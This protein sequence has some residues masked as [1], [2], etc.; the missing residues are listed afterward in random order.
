MNRLVMLPDSH[1]LLNDRTGHGCGLPAVAAPWGGGCGLQAQPLL[2]FVSQKYIQDG[3]LIYAVFPSG[4]GGCFVLYML[5]AYTERLTG[6][7]AA[8]G[9]Q[10]AL[11]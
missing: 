8:T 1:S 3:R 7:R 4:T 6:T 10:E 2:L 5:L 11:I 9:T